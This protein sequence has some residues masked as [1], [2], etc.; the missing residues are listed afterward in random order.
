MSAIEITRPVSWSDKARTYR[1]LLD[2]KEAGRIREGETL[3]LE[4]FP[5]EHQLGAKIDWCRAEP[6]EIALSENETA[7]VSVSNT[8]GPALGLIAVTLW[9]NRYLTLARIGD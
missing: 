4:V 8:H 3:T 7:Q 1:L 9:A 5:G 2:G 6:L